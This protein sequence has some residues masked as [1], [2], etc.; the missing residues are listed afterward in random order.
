MTLSAKAMPGRDGFLFLNGRDSNDLLGHLAGDRPLPD[1]ALSVHRQNSAVIAGL[2]VPFLGIVVPEAHCLYP[3][4]LPDGVRV[5][6]TRPVR[7]VLPEMAPGYVYALDLLA[8]WRDGGGVVYTGRDSHW[9][10]PAALQCW[11]QLRPRLG[12]THDFKL[13][14]TP[15]EENEAADLTIAATQDVVA[16]ERRLLAYAG[17]SY[18]M[19]FASRI[20]NHGNVMVVHNPGGTGRCL[21][22]GT[23]FS[24]RLVPAYASDFAEVVFCY[25]T[26][27]DPF[28]VD[29]VRPD[30]VIAELPERFLHFPALSGRGNTLVSLM[31]G[32]ADHRDAPGSH[33]VHLGEETGLTRPLLKLQRFLAGARAHVDDPPARAFMRRLETIDPELALRIALLQSFLPPGEPRVALRLLLSGQFYNRGTLGGVSKLIDDGRFGPGQAALLPDSENGL[34]ARLRLMLR[35]GLEHRARDALETVL[36]RYGPGPETEYYRRYFDTDLDMATE[37]RKLRNNSRNSETSPIV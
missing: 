7:R 30:C 1:A 2:D 25:G 3:W 23:S 37:T 19:V 14:Y 20:L 9:T 16:A 28:M 33:Q 24:S 13:A 10:Q 26:A 22:F 32:L 29:L 11:R 8:G 12:R 34:L 35:A 6:E 5:S 31:L 21:A 36:E 4:L 17:C 15:S 27:I 18:R